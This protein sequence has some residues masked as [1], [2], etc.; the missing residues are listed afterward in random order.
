MRSRVLLLMVLLASMVLG[1]STACNEVDYCVQTL[2]VGA[3]TGTSATLCGSLTNEG[4]D[5]VQVGFSFWKTDVYT[6]E[7]NPTVL[8]C[9]DPLFDT[10]SFYYDVTGLQPGTSYSYKAWAQKSGGNRLFGATVSFNTEGQSSSTVVATGGTTNLTSSSVTLHGEVVSVG[11]ASNLMVEIQVGTTSGSLGSIY[12]V[13]G[14]IQAPGA[15]SVDLSGLN[16]GT[17]YYYRAAGSSINV[18]VTPG[19]EKS[20]RTLA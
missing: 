13:A 19:E 17:T 16:S 10:E 11:S 6:Q 9:A 12:P 15:F 8:A 3:L 2:N 20:F 7:Q 4:R 5:T 14:T 1:L 18:A